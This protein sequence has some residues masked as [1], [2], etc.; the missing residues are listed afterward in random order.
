[1]NSFTENGGW[2]D[3]ARWGPCS[4]TCGTGALKVRQRL[5][6]NPQPKYGGVKCQGSNIER[7]ACKYKPCPGK[8][9][10]ITTT[11]FLSRSYCVNHNYTGWAKK[12][13]HTECN[14]ISEDKGTEHE[15]LEDVS[16][17]SLRR[18]SFTVFVQVEIRKSYKI[19]KSSPNK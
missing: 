9:Y 12:F 18:Q 4:K 19:K 11:C 16:P 2:S 17:V 6:D 1:L 10:K 8:L 3:W 7:L 14:K 5:C 13:S 15:D